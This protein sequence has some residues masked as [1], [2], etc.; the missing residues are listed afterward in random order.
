MRKRWPSGK[1]ILCLDFDGT[2]YSYS[3][4]WTGLNELLDLPTPG[5]IEFIR[6]ALNSFEVHIYSARSGQQNGIESMQEWLERYGGPD[7]VRMVKWPTSKPPAFVGLDD[8]Q[9][10]FTGV[11]PSVE[12]LLAF[13][14]WNRK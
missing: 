14:P 11:W 1:P 12:S 7:M 10:T 4:G 13:K 5:A 2:V 3:S 9:L 6:E 8:R